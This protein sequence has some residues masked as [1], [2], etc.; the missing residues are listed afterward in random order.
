MTDFEP[1]DALREQLRQSWQQY[2][3]LLE[4]LRP[5]LHRYCRSLTGDVWAAEDLVQDTLLRA[6]G[7]IA[8]LHR[9]ARPARSYVLRIA[10]N[11]WI[12]RVRRG[13]I[14][15]AAIA[16]VDPPAAAPGSRESLGDAGAALLSRL[17]PRE[18][19]AVLLKDVFDLDL[20]E[21]AEVLGSS[22]GAVKAALHRGRAKLTEEP[23]AM[24]EAR[25][26]PPSKAL[27][28]RFVA[29]FNAGDRDAL[30][31]LVLDA[32]P[33]EDVGHFEQFG[34]GAKQSELSWFNGALGL[35]A[36]A[37]DEGFASQRA[38]AGD[39][40]GEPI[41]LLFRTRNRRERLEVVTRLEEEDGRVAGLR[42][43]GFCRETMRELEHELGLDGRDR[44][45]GRE[46]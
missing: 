13:R 40:R 42:S 44:R 14:E 28:E 20:Q 16:Q 29:L 41:L 1:D 46:T 32:A 11:L 27:V 6:F 22:V 24:R 8:S 37:Q 35:I 31:E 26:T 34:S 15:S 19:A 7:R 18:R 21:A 25:R 30:L 5:S 2:L 39:F 33:V 9:D 3:E 10:T 23:D 43:Y 45:E 36:G 38:A 4:P 12:D 17:A